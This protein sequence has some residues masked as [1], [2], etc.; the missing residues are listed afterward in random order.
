LVDDAH[1]IT[2]AFGVDTINI[3]A[4]LACGPYHAFLYSNG[5]VIN[6]GM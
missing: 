2:S 1:A 5:I 4:T 6:L 3:E